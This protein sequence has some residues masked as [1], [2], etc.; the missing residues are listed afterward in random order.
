MKNLTFVVIV[1]ISNHIL[2]QNLEG[3]T[4]IDDYYIQ[5]DTMPT[6][7]N[8]DSNA[9]GKNVLT[10]IWDNLKYPSQKDC[11]GKVFVECIVEPTGKLSNIKTMI[12]L[13]RFGCK[14]FDNE[15]ERV[16]GSMPKWNPGILNGKPVRTKI[17]IPIE[18]K[19]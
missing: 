12:G 5:L 9:L 11:F 4:K 14:E 16:I 15:A 17:V 2:S 10:Y 13:E 6:F 3:P 1:L 8:S 19:I 18:F 7:G